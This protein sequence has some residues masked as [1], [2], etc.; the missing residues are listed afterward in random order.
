MRSPMSSAGSANSSTKTT[1]TK[2]PSVRNCRLRYAAAPSWTAS[3]DLLHL[4]GALAG[5]EHLP[6]QNEGDGQGDEGDHR[7][8]TDKDAVVRPELDALGEGGR[9]HSSSWFSELIGPGNA[10]G[11]PGV[12][13][14]RHRRSA[15]HR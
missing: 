14:C 11:T 7:D 3:A 4:R 9:K 12:N 1:T 2:T 10:D 8:H 15:Q 5:G 6:A 13:T